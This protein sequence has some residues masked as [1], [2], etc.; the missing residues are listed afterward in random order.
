[1]T[2][3]DDNFRTVPRVPSHT[4]REPQPGDIIPVD[5]DRMTVGDV[6]TVTAIAIA[7]SVPWF[8]GMYHI[9]VW[10]AGALS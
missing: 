7:V 9:G 2:N 8:T 6:L 1:M 3:R 5:D 4:R 10:I